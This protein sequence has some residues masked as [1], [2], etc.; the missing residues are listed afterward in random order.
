MPGALPFFRWRIFLTI[1]SAVK[2]I[3]RLLLKRLLRVLRRRGRKGA[4]DGG[5][6]S[7][8]CRS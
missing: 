5:Y 4:T 8:G 1:V 7:G 3:R 6:T 2:V